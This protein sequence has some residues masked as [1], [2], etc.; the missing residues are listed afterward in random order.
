MDIDVV[1]FFFLQG[2]SADEPDSS[3]RQTFVCI[4]LSLAK[5]LTTAILLV[6]EMCTTRPA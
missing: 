2:H 6:F 1:A 5:I 3:M 4:T